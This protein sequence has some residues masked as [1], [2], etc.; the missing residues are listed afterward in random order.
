MPRISRHPPH[1]PPNGTMMI[2]VS[3]AQAASLT[4]AHL[5]LV[6]ALR[7]LARRGTPVSPSEITAALAAAGVPQPPATMAMRVGR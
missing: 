4:C 6:D 3:A 1:L 2:A 5:A 7:R